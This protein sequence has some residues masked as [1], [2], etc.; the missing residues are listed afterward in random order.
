MSD[1]KELSDIDFSKGF[2]FEEGGKKGFGLEDLSDLLPKEIF[3]WLGGG[4]DAPVKLKNLGE[5]IVNKLS[6]VT[7]SVILAQY[8]RIPRLF[9]YIRKAEEVL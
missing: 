3:D 2:S 1:S 4:V 5:D 9:D 8:S 6:W 7:T